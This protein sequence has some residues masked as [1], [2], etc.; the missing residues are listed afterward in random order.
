MSEEAPQPEQISRRDMLGKPRLAFNWDGGAPDKLTIGAT[1]GY[2]ILFEID[3][4]ASHAGG[5][6]EWGVSAIAI[7]ALAIADMESERTSFPGTGART[8]TRFAQFP[9]ESSDFSCTSSV[10]PLRSS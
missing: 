5:A 8:P 7:A 6:P 2:R 10:L 1:G 3:G 9:Q 4:I